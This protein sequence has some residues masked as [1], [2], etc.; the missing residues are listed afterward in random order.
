MG[1]VW[2][3]APFLSVFEVSGL[4]LVLAVLRRVL[5]ALP[6]KMVCGVLGVLSRLLEA[7]VLLVPMPLPMRASQEGKDL[8]ESAAGARDLGE[9]ALHLF[10]LIIGETPAVTGLRVEAH[11]Q[12]CR[13]ARIVYSSPSLATWE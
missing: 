2:H 5:T 8:R 4:P 10:R 1:Y 12:R 6:L 3:V 13:R 7:R 11:G 9:V